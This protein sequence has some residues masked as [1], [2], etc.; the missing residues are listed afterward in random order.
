MG[1]PLQLE[2]TINSLVSTYTE[3][4]A[5]SD[6]YKLSEVKA[7]V[8]DKY[9]L[10]PYYQFINPFDDYFLKFGSKIF[11]IL[12]SGSDNFLSIRNL[13]MANPASVG[14]SSKQYKFLS[15]LAK[16]Y[17]TE[18]NPEI[19]YFLVCHGPILNPMYKNPFLRGFLKFFG[20]QMMRLMRPMEYY[21]ERNLKKLNFKNV[22][23][24]QALHF[25]YGTITGQWVQVLSLMLQYGMIGLHGHTHR[26]R[27]FRYILSGQELGYIKNEGKIVRNPFFIYWDD[28]TSAF[29]IE[30]LEKNRPFELQTPSLG[31]RHVEEQKK[32]HGFRLIGF[33]NDKLKTMAVHYLDDIKRSTA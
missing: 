16:K 33:E 18:N 4:S 24:D 5:Y 31:I 29:T 6:P 7:L 2:N 28:Y 10:K 32:Y 19:S 26:N 8:I 9:C 15:H 30:Y 22:R 13:L 27:E 1:T 14:F 17:M 3:A 23:A 12:N 20:S 11:V 25:N 21:K